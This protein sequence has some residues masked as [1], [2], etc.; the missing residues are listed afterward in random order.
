M[1][2]IAPLGNP[3]PAVSAP[4]SV[5]L[6]IVATLV[7]MFMVSAPVWAQDLNNDGKIDAVFTQK[8]RYNKVCFGDGAG[9]FTQCTDVIG[10]GAFTISNQINTTKATLVDWDGDGSLD[11][12]FA[13]EGHANTVCLNDGHG[14]FNNP[15]VSAGC[16]PLY[17]YNTFPYNTEDLAA[18]DLDGDGAPDLVFANGGNAGLPLAQPN[19][20]CIG[21]NTGASV[22]QEFPGTDAPSTGVALADMNGDGRLD[23][24]FSNRGAKNVVCLNLA[25]VGDNIQFDCRDI[26]PSSGIDATKVTNAVAVGNLIVNFGGAIDGYPDVVFAN[27]GPNE[28]CFGTGDWSGTNVGLN[29]ATFPTVNTNT[30]NDATAVTLS[31]AMAR[32]LLT[33]SSY[34]GDEIVFGND[35]G[36]NVL[37]Y[38]SFYCGQ[39]FQP[40]QTVVKNGIAVSEP[41]PE[42]TTG[43][44]IA[45]VNGDGKLDVVIANVG[46][47]RT[48]LGIYT[49]V[50]A[51]DQLTP[52]SVVLGDLGAP[53]DSTP[54]AFNGVANLI[55]EATGPNGA[56]AT[57]GVTATDNID[58]SVPVSCS[59]ASGTTFALGNTNVTCT[60]TDAAGNTATTSFTVTVRD[61]AGPVIVV[62]SDIV[63]NLTSSNSTVVTYTVTATDAV[64]GAVAFT[65]TPASGSVFF[66]GTTNVACTAT[67]SAG[68]QSAWGRFTVTVSVANNT[69]P[70]TDPVEVSA[71]SGTSVTFAG[72]SS[73]GLTTSSFAPLQPGLVTTP[74]V[75]SSAFAWEVSTTATVT[76]PIVV[77]FTLPVQVSASLFNTMRVWHYEGGNH[78]DRTILT[79]EHR[80]DPATQTICAQT[81]SLSPFVVG[82][83]DMPPTIS[84]DDITVDSTDPAGVAVSFAPTVT[85]DVTAA[86]DLSLSCSPTSGSTFPIGTTPV[87]C[88]ATDELGNQGQLTFNVIVNDRVPPLVQAPTVTPVEATS[89]QGAIVT[90]NATATDTTD[91]AITPVCTPASGTA[92]AVGTTSVTCTATDAAGNSSSATFD[93]IVTDT[94]APVLSLTNVTA[95]ATSGTTAVVDYTASALAA[96]AVDGPITPTCT[97]ASGSAF[98]V[99]T[100]TVTC[101]ATDAHG[102]VA[103]G[104]FTVTVNDGVPPT[105][106]VPG[107]L[108]AQ[109]TSAAGAVVTFSASA[110]DSYDGPQSV[111]CSPAS[112]STFPL[113]QTTVNCS[114]A[115]AAGNTGSASFTVDVVDS[116]APAITVPGPIA[117]SASSASGVSVTFAATAVDAVDGARPVTCAPASGA[118]FLP[119]TTTVNC[120]A[121]DTHGNLSTSSFVVTVTV[122][123]NRIGR[124]V[125]FS[126]DFTVLQDNVTVVSGD[127]G[128]NAV[129]RHKHDKVND[130]DRDDVTVRI[131]TRSTMQSADSRVVG[132]TV[133]L[134]NRASVYNVVENFLINKRGVVLGETTSPVT[135]PYLV[136]PEFPDVTA[137]TQAVTVRAKDHDR[138]HGKGKDDKKGDRDDKKQG[139]P[140]PLAPGRYGAVHVEN[141]AT[142]VLT[143][144]LYEIE[145]LDVDESG[146][147]LVQG[148][149]EVRIASTLDTGSKARIVLDQN[150]PGLTASQVAFYVAGDDGRDKHRGDRDDDGDDPGMV[151]ARI[152]QQNVVQA[153]IYAANGT[154]WLKNG[155]Q[156]TGQFIGQHV[157]IGHGVTLTLA[158]RF[159]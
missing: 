51:K 23:V 147:V 38:N 48:Y 123:E 102:N 79:G 119:G 159:Q 73:T 46:M 137:G 115:D 91:G 128:A 63:V 78:V 95:S 61:T 16:Y 80:P 134:M 65:C 27:N 157:R 150:V 155:T 105:V 68:N 4:R 144:G 133:Q 149:T 71:G 25:K 143:G 33:A 114:A 152:G 18:G 156:A 44:A 87:T 120:Q 88:T 109:A 47:S 136:F 52:T 146:T 97:P 41:I 55:L 118:T 12:V 126:N 131:G 26:E 116:V 117:A 104:S 2:T 50:D 29:C 77:C 39:N 135:M 32:D 112:G 31:V 76:P 139:T 22:C 81:S 130:G 100:T 111:T 129:R 9:G 57:F 121:S 60:A 10:H 30:Q 28:R 11:I 1:T 15:L 75:I 72:V 54:P 49:A 64:D 107:D 125:A 154:V 5:A 93:V 84:Q 40:S 142:L 153:T 106:T 58:G 141:G 82:V 24:L 138:N 70:S 8:Q 53:D 21:F 37:C 19:V 124:F 34:A 85:D 17:G 6:A 113:G 56:A 140:L 110:A 67:D 59:P 148:A 89:A 108:T 90:F 127:V 36:F 83:P 96:D 3:R 86:E 20:A 158:A 7:L 151:V 42:A 92:F 94:T 145:S 13:M 35:G 132:D 74:F 14:N 62:P 66:E 43:V 101:R 99:G 45:D 103:D 69:M 122:V 98:A